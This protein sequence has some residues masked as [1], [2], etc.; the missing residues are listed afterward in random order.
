MKIRLILWAALL[1]GTI[2]RANAQGVEFRDLTFRQALEQ[3]QKEGKLVFMDCYTS[4]CGPCKNMLNNVFTLAEAGEFMNEEF[5]CV[6]YDMEKGEGIELGKRFEVRAFPTFFILRPDGT[7]QHKLVGGSQWERFRMRVERGLNEKTSLLYLEG[8]NQ[9]GKLSTKEYAAYV[10]ALRDAS[11]DKEIETFCQEAFGKLNDKVKCRR[12]NWYLLEQ[13]MLPNDERFIYLVENKSD[14]DKNIGGTIVD[15]RICSVYSDALNRLHSDK[16]NTWVEMCGLI[17]RQSE[18]IEF[19]GKDKISCLLEYIVALKARDVENVLQCLEK[20]KEN[21]PTYVEFDMLGGLN[22]I[23]DLGDNSQV[24][25]Y[26]QLGRE[27][28]NKVGTPQLKELIKRAFDK[29][30]GELTDRTTYV[31]LKGKVTKDKMENVNLYEVV[32]GKERLVATTHISEDGHYGFSFQ[33]AYQGFYT[34]GGEKILD[35][36][37]LYLEP[38][39]RAEVN[40]LED[41]LMI[42]DRNTPENLLLARWESMMIPVRKRLDDMK[43]V[44]FDYR[45][46][47]PYF[48]AFLPQAEK[49]KDEI[50]LRDATFAALVKQTVDYDLDYAAFRILNAL[51]ATKEVYMRDGRPT[52]IPSRPTPADYPE[53]YK[54][55][56]E[57]GKLS[58][59][60]ILRQPYGYDY[61]QRYTTFACG[62]EKER[63]ALEDRLEWLSS[64]PLKAEM[65]LWEMEKCRKY[66]DYI[67][68]LDTYGNYLTTANHQ[69]RLDAVSAKLYKGAAGK[70]ASDFTY[71]DRNGKLVS[72]SD[73]RGKVVVVDVWAT[74]CGPCRA[75]I[76]HLLKLEKEMRG[77]DVVFIGV[78]V[79]EQK[80]YKKWLE[81]LEQEGLEGIQLF[82][83]GK[84]KQGRDKIMNDYKIKGIP[85]F[86]V[87]NKKGKVVTINS[88]RPSSPELKSLLQ[89]LLK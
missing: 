66:E 85:R 76:P 37:R 11:R 80:D 33:P 69:Q 86:M 45:D 5:V 18:K 50:T 88:P 64:D 9:A 19:D 31:E 62:G 43:Y 49:F 87:F 15:E 13:E 81:A 60:S 39:D 25:R 63:I 75:E 36:V 23:V 82:A 27:A 48:E 65:I 3:A 83:N 17:K 44:L 54:T 6:K 22:F 30:Q 4:W 32:D 68:L 79:D 10:N 41:T 46:F 7:V 71:P 2:F 70:L 12:E 57:K 53:Y 73:F 29:L 34:V 21:L 14:F 20:N 40:I 1:C 8:R 58:D 47:Y 51:K 56:V 67:E 28:E 78:S 26:I 16:G 55:I 89:K 24:E 77:K 59:A 61:L 52:H 38:G 84:N 42:T 72:L 35:R 74:W